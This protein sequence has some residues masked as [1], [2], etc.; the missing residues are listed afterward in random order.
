MKH[1][2]PLMKCLVIS[3][4]LLSMKYMVFANELP[5]MKHTFRLN[6]M[7]KHSIEFSGSLKYMF[8][9]EIQFR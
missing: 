2:L 5:S 3:I 9:F 8:T 1:L 6:E 7:L 4:E